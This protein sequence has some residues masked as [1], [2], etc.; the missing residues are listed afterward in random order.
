MIFSIVRKSVSH[1][2]IIIEE[3]NKKKNKRAKKKI[4]IAVTN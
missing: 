4:E 2:V 3:V 1:Y